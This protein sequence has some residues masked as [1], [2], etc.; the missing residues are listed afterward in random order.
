[1]RERGVCVDKT[2]VFRSV[3]HCA[4]ALDKQCRPHLT[5]TND[6]HHGGETYLKIKKQ[7][8]YLYRVIA[9]QG[10]TLDFTL[11]TT[12]DADAAEPFFRHMLQASHMRVP[13]VITVDKNAAYPPAFESLQQEKTLPE[14]CRLRRGIH[15]PAN[16]VSL[17]WARTS[18]EGRPRPRAPHPVWEAAMEESMPVSLWVSGAPDQDLQSPGGAPPRA[19]GPGTPVLGGQIRVLDVVRSDHEAPGKG[20]SHGL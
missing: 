6:S 7:W 16:D 10:Q 9:S 18:A 20:P 2:T 11:S 15:C 4:P 14:S 5:I 3:Q 13:G 12:R 19:H 1:M 8:H 17:V